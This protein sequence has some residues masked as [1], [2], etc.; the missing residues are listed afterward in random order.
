MGF[1]EDCARNDAELGLV[2]TD[3]FAET[4]TYVRKD[5]TE[6]TIPAVID[7]GEPIRDTQ[8]RGSVQRLEIFIAYS[9][10]NS[11]G[12]ATRPA[13]GDAAK[14]NRYGG[15]DVTPVQ[16]SKIVEADKIGWLARFK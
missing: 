2:D 4:I 3:V 1:F 12:L 11:K 9:A 6:Y 10:D 15:T 8:V 16:F 5:G 13:A 7:R 14:I